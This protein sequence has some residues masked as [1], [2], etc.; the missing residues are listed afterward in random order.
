[1]WRMRRAIWNTDRFWSSKFFLN[2]LNR[3]EP[4]EIRNYLGL[5]DEQSK[6]IKKSVYDL[7]IYTEGS[8]T[9]SEAWGIDSGDREI[10]LS[11]F[12]EF[13]KAKNP[14]SKNEMKQEQM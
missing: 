10:V 12:E 1:M 5:L 7:V 6:A 13:V 3:A 9:I 11:S 14:N 8:I 2:F 4:E